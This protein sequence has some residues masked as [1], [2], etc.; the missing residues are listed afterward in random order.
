M[1]DRGKA[2]PI[3]A[4]VLRL[5]AHLYYAAVR[6]RIELFRRGRLASYRLPC[7]VISVGN[8]ALGGTG[9][10]PICIY[11]A[12]LIQK[13][14]YRVV[15]ISRGY[16]GKAERSGGVVSNG[17]EVLLSPAEAGDEPYLM[18][19]RLAPFGIPVIVGQDRVRS[20][21]LALQRFG[22]EVIV[23]DDG[24]QHMRLQRDLDIVLLDADQP[25]G[26]GYLIP[27][28]ILREPL[29]SLERADAV[30][31]TRC[32]PALINMKEGIQQYLSQKD[33]FG[34]LPHPLFAASHAPHIVDCVAPSCVG[35]NDKVSQ[36]PNGFA[37]PV[38]AFSGIARNEAFHEA[39][40]EMGFDL[41]GSESLSDHHFYTSS[42]LAS[43]ERRANSC[44]AQLMV[45]TEKDRVKINGTWI[46][47][48][49]LLVI[50]VD[51]DLGRHAE[52][53]EQFVLE[54][55]GLPQDHFA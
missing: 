40:H 23:L 53:F 33:I 17:R 3:L 49:P 47:K 41:R 20:G 44:G 39:L 54:N 34:D 11:L 13:A 18:A 26:N 52:P 2:T 5:L 43:I 19:T 28:G 22:V 32:P 30:M 25:T 9:K 14:G 55:I 50:G 48:M 45:T 24:F 10:T 46:K 51:M 15:V 8:I 4:S 37:S 29:S 1:Y 21:N 6:F 16:K 31:L 36:P 27:R 42:D 38:Y 12:R 35:Q 7:K